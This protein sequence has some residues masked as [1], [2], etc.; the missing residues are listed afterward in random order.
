MPN[1]IV[2]DSD[3]AIDAL[4]FTLGIQSN[5]FV[6]SQNLCI[7]HVINNSNISLCDIGKILIEHSEEKQ[8]HKLFEE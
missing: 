1:I 5:S 2:M 6:E 3:S 7:K 8:K 4:T